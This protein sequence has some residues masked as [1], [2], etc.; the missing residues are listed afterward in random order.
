VAHPPTDTYLIK[1]NSNGEILGYTISATGV[2]NYFILSAGAWA[3][4]PLPSDDGPIASF[5]D[6]DDL[7]GDAPAPAPTYYAGFIGRTH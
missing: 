4:I 5:D 1:I 7:T 6:F 2:Y 3:D